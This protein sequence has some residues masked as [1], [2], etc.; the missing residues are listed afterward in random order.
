M[1]LPFQ[2]EGAGSH[3]SILISESLEGRIVA[4][5][6]Q[7][8]GRSRYG[9]SP[10]CRLPEKPAGGLNAPGATEAAIVTDVCGNDKWA[11]SSQVAACREASSAKTA[12]ATN[13]RWT[14][15]RMVILG[16]RMTLAHLGR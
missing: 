6:R 7:N 16:L 14:V 10:D 1:N 5:T 2:A 4:A 8:A 9:T 13:A 12:A 3:T 11:R 15:R